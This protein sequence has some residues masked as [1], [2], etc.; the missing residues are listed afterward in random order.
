MNNNN[1]QEFN[2]S[3]FAYIKCYFANC[4]SEKK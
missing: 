2:D 1:I 3:F 4:K